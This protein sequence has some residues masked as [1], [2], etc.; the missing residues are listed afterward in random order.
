LDLHE[1]LKSSEQSRRLAWQVLKEIR[2]VLEILGDQRIPYQGEMKRF[3]AEGDFLLRALVDSITVSRT[4]I[5]RLET[6]LAELEQ[7]AG[8]LEVPREFLKALHYA[9]R[10]QHGTGLSDDQ[11]RERLDK[12]RELHIVRENRPTLDEE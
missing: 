6:A 5:H 1:R 9:L 12:L 11:L 3:R 2:Q 7:L 10:Q 8:R 4:Q